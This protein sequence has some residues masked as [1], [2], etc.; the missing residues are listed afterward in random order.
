MLR[1]LQITLCLAALS[2]LA[3]CTKPSAI[4]E[5]SPPQPPAR[6]FHGHSAA[7]GGK[8]IAVPGGGSISQAMEK[9]TPGDTLQLAPGAYREAVVITKGGAKGAPITVRGSLSPNGE[10]LTRITTG[11]ALEA[12]GWMPAPEVGPGVFRYDKP[13]G[14]KVALLTVDGR[15]IAPIHPLTGGGGINQRTLTAREVLAWPEDHRI[16]NDIYIPR[17]LEQGIPFWETLRA[18]FYLEEDEKAAN[19][20]TLYLRF[21]GGAS[22]A[23]FEI[24]AYPDGS[25]LTIDNA[26]YLAIAD[27]AISGGVSGI[28]ITGEQA[29]YNELRNCDIFFGTDRVLLTGGASRNVIR[30]CH[31]EMRFFG[32]QPGAWAGA[33]ALTDPAAREAAAIRCFIYRHYK[34]W[35]SGHN[36]SNDRSITLKETSDNL[37]WNNELNGG[38]IG[39]SIVDASDILI[40]G[41]RVLHHPRP[42]RQEPF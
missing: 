21:A 41:N 38:L 33:E 14:F 9:A 26:G 28:K 19:G 22:P 24:E 17:Y 2:C 42:V 1:I 30:D 15:Q 8:V 5:T 25:A 11:V 34:G 4:P 18:V 10:K 29:Q 39:I 40:Q 36:I 16:T 6:W 13:L 20:Q 31:L 27:C 32:P 7:S 37:I 23:G 12:A 35:A 3:A